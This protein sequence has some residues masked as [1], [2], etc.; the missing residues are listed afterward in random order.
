MDDIKDWIISVKIRRTNYRNRGG[1][2]NM[3][4]EKQI[5]QWEEGARGT[6]LGAE[7][8]L[9]SKQYGLVLFCC[10]LAVEKLLKAKVIAHKQENP[11]F[12]H[13]LL[14]LA[15]EASIEMDKEMLI[16]LSSLTSFNIRGRYGEDRTPTV[17]SEV[18]AYWIERT[19]EIMTWLEKK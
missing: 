18:A 12:T 11:P 3:S 5:E 6:I 14:R 4:I 2:E 10:H 16:D 13:D 8:L 19:K 1:G 17:N 15:T 9:S 7:A